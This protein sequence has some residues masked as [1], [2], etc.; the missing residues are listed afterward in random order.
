MSF[1]GIKIIKFSLLP[2]AGYMSRLLSILNL[3]ICQLE[4]TSNEYGDIIGLNTVKTINKVQLIERIL[5]KFR[6]T[7]F[8]K[9]E[10]SFGKIINIH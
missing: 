5:F 1:A 9:Q 3:K 8:K 7:P 2:H 6:Q 10:Y 4:S